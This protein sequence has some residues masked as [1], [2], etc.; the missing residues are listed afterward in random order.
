MRLPR[1]MHHAYA[2][3]AGYFWIPCPGCGRAFGGHE[4]GEYTMHTADPCVQRILCREHDRDVAPGVTLQAGEHYY[5][6][7]DGSGTYVLRRD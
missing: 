3:L 5:Q 2:F 1:W 4:T 6:S 7:P